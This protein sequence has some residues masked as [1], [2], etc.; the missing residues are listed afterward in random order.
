M[1][2]QKKPH[3]TTA[4]HIT[5]ALRYYKTKAYHTILTQHKPAPMSARYF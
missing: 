4:T 3:R 5:K 2:V 1:T